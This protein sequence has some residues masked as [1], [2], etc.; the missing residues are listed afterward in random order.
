LLHELRAEARA[1][2][3]CPWSRSTAYPEERTS[4]GSAGRETVEEALRAIRTGERAQWNR[5]LQRAT[6]VGGPHHPERRPVRARSP[7]TVRRPGP[8]PPAAGPAAISWPSKAGTGSGWSRRRRDLQRWRPDGISRVL[9]VARRVRLRTTRDPE[10]QR[11]C[12]SGIDR[13]AGGEY[14]GTS[15]AKTRSTDSAYTSACAAGLVR[16][17]EARGRLMAPSHWWWW[18]RSGGPCGWRW[19]AENRGLD[20]LCGGGRLARRQVGTDSCPGIPDG[21]GRARADRC[22]KASLAE[23]LVRKA[24]HRAIHRRARLATLR[25]SSGDGQVYALPSGPAAELGRG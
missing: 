16:A 15:V 2:T 7:R 8:A 21:E 4:P 11:I 24:R 1:A 17:A 9:V 18:R 13:N 10:E 19:R 5:A 14:C 22:A 20:P 12:L 23:C 3:G 6:G 25:L